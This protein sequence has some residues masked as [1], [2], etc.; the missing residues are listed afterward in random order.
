MDPARRHAL[1]ALLVVQV[2][3][4]TLGV[5]GKV[6]IP[7]FGAD[8]VAAWRI[9]GGALVFGVLRRALGLPGVPRADQARLLLCAAIGIAG[10][11]LL[12]LHGLARTTAVHATLLVT[13]T[14]VFT[15]LLGAALGHERL[16]WRPVLGVGAAVGGVAVL[17][18]HGLAGG[19]VVG[20]LLI[21]GNT[22]LYSFYLVLSRP[23]LQRHPPLSVVAGVFAW[24]VPLTL[25]FT[26]LPPVEA[27]AVAWAAMAW[28][29]AGPTVGTYL[30]NLVALQHV[31]ATVVG[32]FIA[33]QPFVAAALAVPLLGETLGWR[34]V[35]AAS[36]SVGGI[37]LVS[38]RPPPLPPR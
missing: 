2:L 24:G 32:V 8:G 7:H 4:G 19:G 29:L 3:F 14:P 28:I 22:A 25:P 5:V 16:G 17:L 9:A 36:A 1:L 23:L 15:L 20:D 27:P 6:A 34:Q 30:L 37:L 33:L 13:L 26:G 18:S 11:Q 21:V 31:P 38:R 10:N 12:F 35:V